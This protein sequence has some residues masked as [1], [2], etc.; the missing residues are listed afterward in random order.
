MKNLMKK[1]MALV[2]TTA[3]AMTGIAVQLPESINN[4]Q[5][6]IFNVYAA[7]AD[8]P[9][10]TYLKKDASWF[11]TSEAIEV[12]DA[13]ITYQVKDESGWQKGMATSHTGD[14]AHSTIDND[15][16]TSQIR[17]LMRTY[18]ATG[19]KKYFDCAM[20]GVDCLFKMQYDNGG[21]MQCLNTPG[22]YHAHITLNDGAYLHVLEI[23]KEMK[24]KTGDFSSVSDN[25]SKKAA[26]SYEKGIQC[27]LDM[28]IEVNGVKTAW[29]QQHDEKT[30]APASA[31]AYELPSIC[32]SESAGVIKAL[33]AEA[34]ESGRQDIAHAVNESI[35][36][37]QKATLY[38]I[39]FVKQGDDKVVV[40]DSSASPIWA[41]FYDL[42]K[43]IPMF[44]DRDG[45]VHYDVSEISQERRTGYAW[46][47]NW[48]KDIVTLELLPET[49][50]TEPPTQPSTEP[51]TQPPT[52]PPTEQPTEPEKEFSY[53]GKLISNL[54]I[55]DTEYG[56][57]WGIGQSLST[58]SKIYGD[59]DFTITKIPEMLES[60]E[61]IITACDSKKMTSDLAELT[62]S[63][64]ATVYV[65][66][67]QRVKSNQKITP[68]WLSDWTKE[69][70]TVEASNGVVYEIYSK[71]LRAGEKITL[72]SN[73]TSTSVVNY[74]GAV[75]EIKNNTVLYDINCDG[76]FNVSDVVLLQ[77]WLLA[78]PDTHLADW[79][80]GDICDDNVLDVFDFCLM[81]RAL[82]NQ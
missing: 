60:A 11:G 64:N 19:E 75:S 23:M 25:Y 54:T 8:Y 42:E 17:F 82:L 48:G 24:N 30:L 44:S 65:F 39:K 63:Q 80:A 1:S 20:R 41:R 35:K 29:C 81:K 43:E 52:E 13:C 71:E 21:W 34:K 28:Q 79:K 32:T 56:T 38:G 77:K 2:F 70:G 33:Y 58:G 55:K 14:W 12:A 10:S 5:S 31:R 62:V 9:W 51:P 6:V 46:Y 3:I 78:V 61:Y 26:V 57:S 45:S 74:F 16:T 36:W 72:G 59:R 27:L 66:L 18:A 40:E 67:D 69:I 22:T 37:F 73:G 49:T 76:S 68:D 50:G 7:E 4:E 15:A 47:G 53:T